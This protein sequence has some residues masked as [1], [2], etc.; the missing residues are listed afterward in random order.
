MTGIPLYRVNGLKPALESLEVEAAHDNRLVLNALTG[1]GET[2][3]YSGN[4]IQTSV[5]DVI[6][7]DSDSTNAIKI[8]KADGI[9]EIMTI[10]TSNGYIGIR[11]SGNPEFAADIGNNL[12]TNSFRA[13]SEAGYMLLDDTGF[14][15]Y[16]VIAANNGFLYNFTQTLG[17]TALTMSDATPNV[18][19]AAQDIFTAT[20]PAG[21][22]TITFSGPR[23]HMNA[24]IKIKHDSSARVLTF[25]TAY[26][27]GQTDTSAK[28][29]TLPAGATKYTHFYI[30]YDGTSYYISDV[31]YWAS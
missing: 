7:P 4:P 30:T 20:M 11:Q 26:W 2:L 10:D 6:R 24:V 19:F 1:N 25:P 31:G 5:F 8:T 21:N 3:L 28:A 12:L 16:A 27:V 23:A 9:T 14:Q 17:A 18:N 29:Y 15:L 13:T 22:K